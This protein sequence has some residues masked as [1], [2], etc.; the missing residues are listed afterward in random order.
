MYNS[1]KSESYFKESGTEV[2]HSSEKKAD[3]FSYSS[4]RNEFW[5]SSDYSQYRNRKMK[6]RT[7]I[8]KFNNAD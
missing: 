5:D 8:Y 4:Q 3:D 2:S 1:D 6:K 7:I